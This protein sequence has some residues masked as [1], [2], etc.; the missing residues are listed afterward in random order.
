[1]ADKQI[2]SR[3]CRAFMCGTAWKHDMKRKAGGVPIYK[4]IHD[5]EDS[6]ACSEECGLVEVEVRMVRWVKKGTI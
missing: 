4:T 6:H 3:P 2:V 1:M 5:F